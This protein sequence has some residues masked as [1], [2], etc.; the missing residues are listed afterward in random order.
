MSDSAVTFRPGDTAVFGVTPYRVAMAWPEHDLAII[1]GRHVS[2]LVPLSE[3]QAWD[4]SHSV[5]V[6]S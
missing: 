5:A 4:A 3:L 6:C 1:Y 2:A